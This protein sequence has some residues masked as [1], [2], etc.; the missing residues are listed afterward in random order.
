MIKIKISYE[1]SQ[2]LEEI[3]KRLQGLPQKAKIP[4]ADTGRFKRAYI[5]IP[6]CAN[7]ERF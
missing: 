4:K 3:K 5:L 2:E 1:D 7:R 6:T